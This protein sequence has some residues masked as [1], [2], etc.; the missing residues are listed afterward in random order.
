MNASS[1]PAWPY[2]AAAEHVHQ[3]RAAQRHA[4]DRQREER[5]R[6]ERLL[7]DRVETGLARIEAGDSGSSVTITK[8]GSAKSTSN[9][10]YATP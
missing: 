7:H 6:G 5:H 10:L 1:P 2:S 9:D 4:G 3:L 8:P